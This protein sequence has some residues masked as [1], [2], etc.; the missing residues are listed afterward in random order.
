MMKVHFV[1]PKLETN[2]RATLPQKCKKKKWCDMNISIRLGGK[3]CKLIYLKK[4]TCS[5]NKL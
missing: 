5:K 3:A 2:P 4:C 1:H